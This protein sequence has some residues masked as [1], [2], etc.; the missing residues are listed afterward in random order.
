MIHGRK[1]HRADRVL[2]EKAG[3]GYALFPELKTTA[4]FNPIMVQPVACKEERF[5]ACLG[6]VE[7]GHLDLPREAPLF[8][9]FRGKL[10]AFPHG[11]HDDQ[12]DS[13]SQFV[14]RQL[15]NWLWILTETTRDGRVRGIVRLDKLRW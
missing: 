9:A 5:N 11:K 2:I 12:V 13:F 7:A 8:D 15:K 4:G 1:Q 14:I 6:E 3:S 10:R